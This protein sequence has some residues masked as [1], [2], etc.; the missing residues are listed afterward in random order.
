M[1]DA[2]LKLTDD[3][4]AVDLYGPC[5]GCGLL[6]TTMLRVAG[7]RARSIFLD[8]SQQA[9]V[10]FSRHDGRIFDRNFNVGVLP[11]DRV[12]LCVKFRRP[13]AATGKALVDSIKGMLSLDGCSRPDPGA[14]VRL[15]CFPLSRIQMQY[16]MQIFSCIPFARM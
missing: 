8:R 4:T 16:A 14:I 11:H 1:L 2:Y 10:V 15:E 13:F 9:A 3:W 7:S 6:L 12:R 5:L